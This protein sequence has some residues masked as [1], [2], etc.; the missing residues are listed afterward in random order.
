MLSIAIG[1]IFIILTG[2]FFK[3]YLHDLSKFESE[4]LSSSP[5]NQ[6]DA[7]LSYE[8]IKQALDNKQNIDK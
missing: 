8:A 2:Y 6:D 4:I 1:S 5:N 7:S 3:K